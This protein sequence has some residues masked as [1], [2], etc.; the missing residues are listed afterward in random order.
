LSVTSTVLHWPME[1]A[2]GEPPAAAD[3]TVDGSNILLDLHGDPTR[4][5]LVVFS[6]GNHHMALEESLQA[7]LR[8]HLECEDVFYAT[9]P[10]R[11]VVEALASGVL[12]SGNL[13][14]RCAAHVFISPDEVLATLH[15]RGLV[16]VPA[17]FMRSDGLALLYRRENPAGV[18]A[19]ED[20]LR[21]DL[22]L[23]LSNPSTESASFSVYERAVLAVARRA[24]EDVEAVRRRLHGES[25]LKSRVIHHREIPALIAAD[26]AD[27][28]LV[29]RHL[30]LR[31]TRIFPDVF[32]HRVVDGAL[33]DDG[34]ISHYH[35]AAVGDAGPYG[36]QLLEFLR[37]ET[38]A[39]IYRSHG[40][41]SPPS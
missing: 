11:I 40:L 16:G 3:L 33:L 30:A 34:C 17:P 12:S 1:N 22:R 8:L 37:S 5:R 29:Y 41:A 35:A 10:P 23:A 25:V 6:D 18:G 24:G 28:S 2:T 7:F 21:A 13:R 4:A 20:L 38:V 32:A 39:R 9:T 14:L 26:R 27:L 31:Y 15:R 36:R 19:A